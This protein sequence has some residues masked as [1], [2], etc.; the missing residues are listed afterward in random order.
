MKPRTACRQAVGRPAAGPPRPGRPS[1][2]RDSR[3]VI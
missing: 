1:A 3:L 2:I